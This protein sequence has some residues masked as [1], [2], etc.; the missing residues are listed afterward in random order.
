MKTLIKI[1]NKEEC[2][3]VPSITRKKGWWSLGGPKGSKD[4]VVSVGLEGPWVKYWNIG[5]TLDNYRYQNWQSL[6]LLPLM[7]WGNMFFQ[8]LFK[9]KTNP[10]SN[11][12]KR[13]LPL[14]SCCHMTIQTIFWWKCW[15]TYGTHVRLFSFM[16]SF[17]MCF[18]IPLSFKTSITD[19]TIKGSISIVKQ[20]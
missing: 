19:M 20:Y 8:I 15:C 5:L 18:Q 9:P 14:M 10:T 2:N 13:F 7:K 11:A 12:H 6:S 17:N 1:R 4:L 16:N 3:W